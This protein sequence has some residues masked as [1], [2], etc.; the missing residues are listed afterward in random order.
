MHCE[1]PRL[2]TVAALTVSLEKNYVINGRV[3]DSLIRGVGVMTKVVND[4]ADIIWWLKARNHLHSV[5]FKATR[6]FLPG[7]HE[8]GG[9]KS[10]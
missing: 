5:W 10:T 8:A 2:H 6:T 4:K 1:P 7:R 3:Y 9:Q